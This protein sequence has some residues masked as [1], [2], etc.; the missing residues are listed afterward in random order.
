MAHGLSVTADG[1]ERTAV[2][3]RPGQ[4]RGNGLGAAIHQGHG[5]RGAAV[6]LV[7]T[8]PLESLQVG[9]QCRREV[10]MARR[11]DDRKGG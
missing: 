11:N 8:R 9:P 7:G 5:R 10:D 2:E 4:G 6:E 3:L 1:D